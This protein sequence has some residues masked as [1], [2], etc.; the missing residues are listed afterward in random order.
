MEEKT[1]Q[2]AGFWRRLA[3]YVI[4]MVILAFANYQ[5]LSYQSTNMSVMANLGYYEFTYANYGVMIAVFSILISWVYFCGME[6]SPLQATLG[7]LAVGIYVT[8][9]EGQRVSFGKATGRYFAKMISGLILGIGFIMAGY[10]D[11]KQ[12]LHDKIAK[13]LVLSK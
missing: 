8:D 2:Y 13:C 7:K 11:K 9:L 1:V 6:S 12:A 4:D 10:T 3:A 5:Y